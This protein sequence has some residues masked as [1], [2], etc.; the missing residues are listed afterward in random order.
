MNKIAIKYTQTTLY[1]RKEQFQSRKLW[2]NSTF[3]LNTS[4]K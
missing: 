1:H 4:F 3:Q 2:N